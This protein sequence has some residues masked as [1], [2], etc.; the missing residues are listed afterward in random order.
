MNSFESL[1]I[2]FTAAIVVIVVVVVTYFIMARL[3]DIESR[4][5]PT[6]YWETDDKN[7]VI[8]Y[9]RKPP[10]FKNTKDILGCCGMCNHYQHENGC[11]LHG[12]KYS[13]IGC[14][15]KTTCDDWTLSKEFNS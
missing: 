13:G 14:V 10:H 4:R 9:K 2:I 15:T 11:T 3:A 6:Y 12:V 1:E 8:S 7:V 5:N